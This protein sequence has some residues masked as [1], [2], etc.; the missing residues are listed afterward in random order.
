MVYKSM[1]SVCQKAVAKEMRDIGVGI[2]NKIYQVDVYP[3]LP[4]PPQGGHT[5]EVID[6]E[7]VYTETN[8]LQSHYVLPRQ[9]QI[10]P[11]TE[12]PISVNFIKYKPGLRL[13]FPLQ[14]RSASHLVLV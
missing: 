11:L 1:I 9:I 13:R 2:E 3:A 12:Q 6:E 4:P 8:R 7:K 10:D 5:A 14:V